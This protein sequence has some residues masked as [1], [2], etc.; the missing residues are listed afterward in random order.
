MLDITHNPTSQRF[1]TTQDGVVCHI[2]YKTDSRQSADDT[3]IFDH[4]IVP[5]AVGGQGIGSALV[6]HALDYAQA[7]G[8]RVV[9]QCPFVGDYIQ[10]HPEYKSLLA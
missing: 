5:D 9:P 1:E 2:S 3:L 7:E 8:K 10:K 6:K 4:T